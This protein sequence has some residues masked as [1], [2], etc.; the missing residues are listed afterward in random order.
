MLTDIKMDEEIKEP[1]L[2]I[3]IEKNGTSRVDTGFKVDFQL[4]LSL[5]KGGEHLTYKLE[6]KRKISATSLEE[7]LKAINHG[8]LDKGR[9]IIIASSSALY[10]LDSS[11]D[12]YQI[13]TNEYQKWGLLQAGK[14]F[15]DILSYI[16]IHIVTQI[17]KVI[18]NIDKGKMGEDYYNRIESELYKTLYVKIAK[19]NFERVGRGYKFKVYGKIL[20]GYN[21]KTKHEKIFSVEVNPF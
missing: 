2:E 1:S 10:N 8:R 13:N 14:F 3:K 17:S 15:K 19:L 9:R 20:C 7:I 4:E 12:Y 6:R 5:G 21:I 11:I 18:K 16:G